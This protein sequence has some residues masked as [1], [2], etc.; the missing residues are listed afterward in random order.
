MNNKLY[1]NLIFELSKPGRRSYSLPDNGMG[2]Y[3][4]APSMRR[5]DDAQLPECDEMTVVRH[6]ARIRTAS[7][8]AAGRD[9]P[10]S[11][12]GV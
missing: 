10:G 9:M 4:L 6:Y 12:G 3:E 2:S 1:G 5:A 8:A 11:L 7:S